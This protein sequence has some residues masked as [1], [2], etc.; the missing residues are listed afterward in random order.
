[1]MRRLVVFV[2]RFCFVV[3]ASA[4]CCSSSSSLKRRVRRAIVMMMSRG[5]PGE[6]S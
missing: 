5:F 4:R 2:V 1:M 3:R 6:A